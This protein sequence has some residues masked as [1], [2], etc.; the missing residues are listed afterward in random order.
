MKDCI[1]PKKIRIGTR[2]SHLALAQTQLFIDELHKVY[3]DVDCEKV[4]IKTTGDKIL[5]KPLLE[6]GGKAV[7]VTEFEAAMQDGL[8]DYAVHSAKDMPMELMSG[9][10]IVCVLGREDARDVLITRADYKIEEGSKAVVGT[11]S[12]SRQNQIKMI[13]PDV[14]CQSLRGN[15]PTRIEKLRKG[16]FDGI[17][18]AAAGLKRLGLH[19]ED[20]LRYEYFDTDKMIPAAGQGIIAVEGRKKDAQEFLQRI[21]DKKAETELLIERMVLR[22]LGA[23]CHEPIGVY[24]KL[25]D[26]ERIMLCVVKEC[27]GQ[28]IKVSGEDENEFSAELADR[29]VKQLVSY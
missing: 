23:G 10:D 3:P 22:K 6:F 2:G 28:M 1:V 27:C 24:S 5:D 20:D 16:E 15:V 9:M 8:I 17:I 29:L 7:F 19:N 14:I 26:S 12:L 11:G 13:Y 4:I 25:T 18:L 21:S